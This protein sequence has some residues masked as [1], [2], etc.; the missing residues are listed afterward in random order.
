M[1]KRDR[2]KAGLGDIL[3]GHHLVM[4]ETTENFIISQCI[5]FMLKVVSDM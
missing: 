2:E 4:T 5:L 3:G 1:W